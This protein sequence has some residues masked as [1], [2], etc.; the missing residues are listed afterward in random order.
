M[1]TGEN[2]DR[3]RLD[4]VEEA[5]G[6]L[7]KKSAPY[8]LVDRRVGFR[9]SLNRG[10]CSIGRPEKLVAESVRLFLVPVIRIVNIRFRRRAEANAAGHRSSRRRSFTSAQDAP[11]SFSSR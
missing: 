6:E 7:A 2:D 9:V 10:K 3:I 4:H 8:A 1:K 11:V 5:V